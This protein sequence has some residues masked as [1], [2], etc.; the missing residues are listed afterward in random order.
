MEHVSVELRKKYM[1]IHIYG[2]TLNT[3][4]SADQYYSSY[5]YQSSSLISYLMYNDLH[6]DCK[7]YEQTIECFT[8]QKWIMIETAP[9]W[10]LKWFSIYIKC[11]AEIKY[12]WKN[13][14]SCAIIIFVTKKMRNITRKMQKQVP[15]TISYFMPFVTKIY[16]FLGDDVVVPSIDPAKVCQGFPFTCIH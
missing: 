3:A 12:D 15:M 13:S 16:I 6:H 10:F 7:P 1:F 5:S 9:I 2:M 14:I 11:K 4:K 8:L